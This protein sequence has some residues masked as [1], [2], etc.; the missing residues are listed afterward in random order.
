MK[1]VI[2][3]GAVLIV[4]IISI[5]FSTFY[6]TKKIESFEGL[7][8]EISKSVDEENWEESLKLADQTAEQ[9]QRVQPRLAILFHHEELKAI[10]LAL[11]SLQSYIRQQEKTESAA[12]LAML[13]FGI[14]HIARKDKLY[15]EN[16]L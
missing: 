9:W 14:K 3:S 12:Q 7:L 5:V 8:I 1:T 10:S 11:V 4:I 16:V 2:I 15:I 6:T 13:Q